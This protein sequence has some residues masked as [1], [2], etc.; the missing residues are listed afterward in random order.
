MNGFMT[1]RRFHL[2]LKVFL[3][4]F[5]ICVASSNPIKILM[6]TKFYRKA[7]LLLKIVP[8]NQI[9]IKQEIRFFTNKLI[10]WMPTFMI[11]RARYLKF[12]VKSWKFFWT[13]LGSFLLKMLRET[14]LKITELITFL[15]IFFFLY[16]LQRFIYISGKEVLRWFNS[17]DKLCRENFYFSRYKVLND[18]YLHP[19]S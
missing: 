11:V 16:E 7:D 3:I 2:F 17:A 6:E 1:Y 14:S 18:C 9:S 13:L 8:V 5:N 4:D 12:M 10:S 15:S 19:S